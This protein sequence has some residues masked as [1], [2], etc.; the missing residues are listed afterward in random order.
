MPTSTRTIE[1]PDPEKMATNL[2]I[3]ADAIEAG[4]RV[5]QAVQFNVDTAEAKRR[6]DEPP[7]YAEE[8]GR[9]ITIVYTPGSA[10]L[11][12]TLFEQQA[13]G[14]LVSGLAAALIAA[15]LTNGEVERWER[16]AADLARAGIVITETDVIKLAQVAHKNLSTVLR[17]YFGE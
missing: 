3:W 15:G 5:V 10:D 8:T 11:D 17:Q 1:Y 2:R 6:P 13:D 14:A 9:S 4:N 7:I 16:I 12:P